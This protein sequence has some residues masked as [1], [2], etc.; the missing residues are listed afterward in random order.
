MRARGTVLASLCLAVSIVVLAGGS[1][2]WALDDGNGKLWRQVADTTGV[3]AAEV[4]QVCPQ[5]GATR[6]SGSAGGRV[7][8]DWIWATADQVVR[9]DG[10]LR[11]RDP[12][13]G[14]AVD[15]RR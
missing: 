13:G 5:D 6:C 10:Q 9:P 1:P 15:R 7:F 3:T 2:A 12:C 4:A 14:S 8:T 11:A